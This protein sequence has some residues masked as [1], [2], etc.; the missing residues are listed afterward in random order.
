MSTLKVFS[1]HCISGPAWGGDF[2]KK[3]RVQM[4][5]GLTDDLF[6]DDETMYIFS[7]NRHI[8]EGYP[9]MGVLRELGRHATE[10]QF[11]GETAASIL[12]KM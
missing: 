12:C 2:D 11:A 1:R 4:L 9:F 6:L 8:D 10:N 3:P 5:L 7:L